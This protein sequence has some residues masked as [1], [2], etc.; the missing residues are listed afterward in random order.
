[1]N[2]FFIYALLVLAAY[3]LGSIP[4]GL[5]IGFRVKGLD[6]REHGSKNIGATNV[7]RVVGKKWGIS[8][9][10]LDALKGYL[11]CILPLIVGKELSVGSQLLLGVGAILG[12]SFPVW[13]KFKGGK[14]VATSLGVFWAIAWIPTVITFGIWIICFTLTHIISIASLVAAIVFPAMILWCYG[15]TPDLKYLLPISLSLAAFIFYTH[16]ANITRLQQ[17]TEKKLF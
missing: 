8:V 3:L 11:A 7:S 5:I 17:G 15:G 16:R 4:F 14:G 9:L 1:M 12:H 13:L 6:I 2:N 10:L